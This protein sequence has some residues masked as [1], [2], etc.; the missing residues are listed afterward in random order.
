M[1]AR[2][3][4]SEKIDAMLFCWWWCCCCCW[5]CY[6]ALL[7]STYC[8]ESELALHISVKIFWGLKCEM[9]TLMAL[10]T[11]AIVYC[12]IIYPCSYPFPSIL[13]HTLRLAKN[14]CDGKFPTYWLCMIVC[15]VRVYAT[16]CHYTF[17]TF[18][19]G[20]NF[21]NYFVFLAS[22]WVSIPGTITSQKGS[23][24]LKP[25]KH[26][27]KSLIFKNPF[28][29]SS[30]WIHAQPMTPY[31]FCSHYYT[32]VIR[33]CYFSCKIYSILTYIFHVIPKIKLQSECILQTPRGY[34]AHK[35]IFIHLRLYV[36]ALI[37]AVQLLYYR[38]SI[39]WALHD[40]HIRPVVCFLPLFFKF[41]ELWSL[42]TFF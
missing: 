20:T 18:L 35:K 8:V 40:N 37:N 21:S 6:S 22:F 10:L 3:Q 30:S 17:Q 41:K 29:I 27:R 9:V 15:T 31:R 26:Q 14:Q 12:G 34:G 39:D 4:E 28:S 23:I 11:I 38:C 2:E 13:Y 32:I 25:K 5:C 19:D 24:E 33:L 42:S 1:K 16:Q 36:N 7:K